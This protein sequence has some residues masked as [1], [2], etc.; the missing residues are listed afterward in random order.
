MILLLGA[1][2]YIG[3]AF[4][5][6]I[7]ERNIKG[8]AWQRSPG[9][10]Y[11]NR[12]TFRT[13]LTSIKAKVV[14]NCAAY[15]KDGVVDKCE[16]NKAA[17]LATN[18]ALPVMLAEECSMA[19]VTLLHV[20]TGCLFNGDNGGKGW[21]EDDIPQLSFSRL[22][23]TYVGAKELAERLIRETHKQHYI[24]RIRLP[25]DRYDYHRNYISKLMNYPKVV[26]A[27]NSISHRGDFVNACLDLL[28][29]KAPFGTYN[30]TN[31][32]AVTA[33]GICELLKFLK[34]KTEFEYWDNDEFMRTVARTPKSNCV[35]N[36]DKLIS[37]GVEIRT[38]AQAV[39]DSIIRWL[40]ETV[41]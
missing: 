19:G 28:K 3:S 34:R 36:V 26:R 10:D 12:A 11:V 16:D 38:V 31:P 32:G 17:T 14:I 33:D 30:V 29:L 41:I 24:C 5:R 23:G 15:V 4:E 2:G 35:L 13:I 27:T 21:S 1:S 22:C 8:I 37:T 25:F 39:E 9:H 7:D 18:L 40:P 20:S 6:A